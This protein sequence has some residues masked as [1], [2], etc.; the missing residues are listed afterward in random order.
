[1]LQPCPVGR[2]APPRALVPRSRQQQGAARS[3]RRRATP[4]RAQASAAARESDADA[5]YP[6]WGA[7][8]IQPGPLRRTRRIAAGPGFWLFEQTQARACGLAAT[9]RRR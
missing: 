1:M 4:C 9:A 6:L 5:Y 3:Q 8:P 2:Q 7:L